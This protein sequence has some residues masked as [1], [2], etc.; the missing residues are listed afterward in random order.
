MSP[1]FSIARR[2]LLQAFTTPLAWLVLACWCLL[3]NGM[4]V[5]GLFQVHGTA[6]SQVP[7]FVNALYSGVFFLTLLAPALSMTSFSG[8]RVQGTMQLLL[9]VPIKE[10]H[11]VAGK[12]LGVFGVLVALIL[13][14]ISHPL[15]LT[16]ISA[17]NLPHL[18]AG[19]LGLLLACSLFAA[20]GVWI[21]LL[22]DT[23][24]AAY[25]ITFAV[26]AILILLGMLEQAAVFGP[27][28]QAIGLTPRV[29][30]FFRGEIR[31]GNVL[32]LLSATSACLVLAHASLCA[33]RIHG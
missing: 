32:F 2:D 6:G 5:W 14:T 15:V 11:L 3:T 22:V 31:L 23:P 28:G 24:I 13:S 1:I 33:R 29:G 17:V 20:L 4:F 21:S 7:L 12:F 8:E 27:L 30:P 16:F 9:T 18:L 26:I 19:Y 10:W 25:V